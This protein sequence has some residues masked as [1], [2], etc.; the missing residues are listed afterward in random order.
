MWS[1]LVIVPVAEPSAMWAPEAF[2]SVRLSVSL[3]SSCASSSTATETVFPV[4]PAAKVSVPLVA[5]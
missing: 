5:V 2:D 4:S 3:P 1:L